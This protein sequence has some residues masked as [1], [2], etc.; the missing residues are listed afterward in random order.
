V[1]NKDLFI[2]LLKLI[3]SILLLW[4]AARLVDFNLLSEIILNCDPSYIVLAIIL[5]LGSTTLAAYRWSLIM[6]ALKFH[7]TFSFYLTRY[8]KG[9]F[10]NQALPGSIGGDAVRGLELG[11]MGYS[12]RE[13]FSGIFI[14]RIVGLAGLLILNLIANLASDH[15]LNMAFNLINTIVSVELQGLPFNFI[16]YVGRKNYRITQYL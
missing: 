5:Q 8:F 7:E 10:F 6:G 15:L 16:A 14:D 1:F 9:A 11:K 13:A 12:K 4:I 3:V 2:N